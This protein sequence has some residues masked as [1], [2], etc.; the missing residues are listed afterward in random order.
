[1]NKQGIRSTLHSRKLV[2]LEICHCGYYLHHGRA[3]IYGIYLLFDALVTLHKLSY[4]R[5]SNSPI[6]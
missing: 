5:Y 2:E 3:P 1:M 6:N 4:L